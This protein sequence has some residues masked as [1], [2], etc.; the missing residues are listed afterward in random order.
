MTANAGT[1]VSGGITASSS[2]MQQS[3]RMLLFPCNCER[4]HVKHWRLTT[5][6]HT[7]QMTYHDT[8]VTDVDARADARGADDRVLSHEHVVSDVKR[9]KRT[10][11]TINDNE[12]P[13]V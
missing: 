3:L 10:P 1:T 2:M 13:T 8:V 12:N 5:S 9:E 7:S 6:A 4:S 11:V